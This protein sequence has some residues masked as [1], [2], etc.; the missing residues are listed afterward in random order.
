MFDPQ[1][2]QAMLQVQQ[3]MQQLQGSPLFGQLGA[4]AGTPGATATPGTGQTDPNALL[5]ALTGGFGGMGGLGALGG[6][7]GFPA[8]TPPVADPETAYATQL[9]QLQDMGFFDREANIRALQASG[10]NVH[11]AVERLLTQM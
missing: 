3:A 7:G 9:T 10:G 2:M 5:A 11:A 1:N 8:A 4:A 6:L